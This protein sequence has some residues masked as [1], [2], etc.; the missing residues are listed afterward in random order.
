MIRCLK[1]ISVLAILLAGLFVHELSA[2]VYLLPEF[3]EKDT[4]ALTPKNAPAGQERDKGDI[5]TTVLTRS[6]DIVVKDAAES[7]V[8]FEDDTLYSIKANL[9][10]FS[11]R[12][13]C[14]GGH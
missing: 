6:S 13:G 1:T 8:I 7:F 5:D 12:L 9:G 2:H 4:T 10:P 11:A 3:Q 14:E